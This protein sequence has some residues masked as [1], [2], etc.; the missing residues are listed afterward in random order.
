M[1]IFYA[2]IS[3]IITVFIF[4]KCGF[5]KKWKKRNE[6]SNKIIAKEKENIRL[7]DEELKRRET[8]KSK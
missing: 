1:N 3:I 4:D 6:A 7:I 8:L 5:Y 2:I